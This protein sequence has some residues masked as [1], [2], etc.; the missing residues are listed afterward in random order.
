MLK[1]SVRRDG[2][3]MMEMMMVIAVIAILATMAIPSYIDRIVRDQITEALPLADTAKKPI[4]AA[5]SSAHTLPADNTTALLPAADKIV[6]NFISSVAVQDGAIHITFGNL[7]NGA[8]KG[9]I[10]TL[11]PAVVDDAPIVPIT[12]VCGMAPPPDK[13]TAKGENRTNIQG[14]YLPYKCR[15]KGGK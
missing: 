8:I 5:W 14:S 1:K 15:G 2:F 13:M 4:E 7:A 3:T 6:N 11:R 9:K 10:L 12:W